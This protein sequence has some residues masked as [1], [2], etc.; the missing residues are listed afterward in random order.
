M[1]RDS[2]LLEAYAGDLLRCMPD[3]AFFVD[4]AGR[5]VLLNGLAE[6]M[7][8][9]ESEELRGKSI[10]SLIPERFR[11]VHAGHCANYSAQP[12][13]RAMGTGLSLHALRKDG[14]EFPVEI[15]LS[16]VETDQ[17]TF[18]VGAIRDINQAEERYRA[19]FEHV[20]V[21]VVHSTTEGR[22]LNVNPKFCEMAGY[23]REELLARGIADLT[24]PDD[25]R[26]SM[27]TRAD[28]IAGTRSDYARE[29]R[30]ICKGG[31]VLWTHV[32]TSLVRG[33]DRRP[34]HFISIMHDISQQKQAELATAESE[35][36]FRA[37]VEQ[38]VSGA[39]IVDREGRFLYLNPRLVE[40]LG[41]E[42]DEALMGRPVLD[43][44]A[45]KSHGIVRDN[46]VQRIA[47]EPQRARYHFDGIRKD[48]S[49]VTLGAHANL[50]TYRGQQ[51]LIT[52]VQDVTDLV[53]AETEVNHYVAKLQRAVEGTI[54]VI[55][56]IGE[57]RDP[58]THGHEHR[59]GEIATAIAIEMGLPSD[60]VEGVRIAG[61]LHDVG[62]IAV[63][64][65]ILSKPTRL[66]TAEFDLVKQHAQQSYDIL[67]G[68]EFPWP[69]AEAAWQHHERLDGS[70]YPRGLKGAEI[71]LDARI[72]AV[73][74]TVEA[75]A[76]HRPY[77]PGLGIDK[78]LAEIERGR[79]T[80]FDPVV[81]NACLRLFRD[82]G[83]RIPN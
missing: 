26:K 30:L 47:G 58:Y 50:G 14:V 63:P 18:V 15:S 75:M 11:S 77:R 31:T 27:E 71:I 36:R 54:E 70:G 13:P 59:V 9:Y 19:V 37:M 20:A 25:I 81:A 49:P 72:L 65:E 57:L 12:R 22:I 24:H 1:N 32:T 8:G 64:A 83:Y 35:E 82:N 68:T 45:E 69:V 46:M 23:S 2:K 78:A 66:T 62:K 38:S 67:K 43:F 33:A 48:G 7:F 5:I 29:A 40:I 53:R 10:G 61:Y 39:C 55:S 42:S 3:A 34:L 21:G 41:Y 6:E 74:D 16:P 80:V 44:V 76:S 60:R 79:G 56:K 51:V 73:A 28:V 52:T 17:G 4:P